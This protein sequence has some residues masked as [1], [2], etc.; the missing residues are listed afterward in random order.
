MGRGT[1]DG[2]RPVPDA[3]L[4]AEGL[5]RIDLPMRSVSPKVR[6]VNAWRLTRPDGSADLYDTGTADASAA[7]GLARGLRGIARLG[8]VV[9]GHAH[10]DH[11]GQA[12][13][14][15]A[16]HGADLLAPMDP[17]PPPADPEAARQDFLRFVGLPG[18]AGREAPPW[19][20]EGARPVAGGATLRLGRHLWRAEI[21]GGHAPASLLLL[22]ECGR[23][24][25]SADQLLPGIGSFVGVPV[26]RP[27]EDTLARQIAHMRRLAKLSPDVTALPGHGPAFTG[28]PAVADWQVA[29]Y[30]RR[31]ER[32]LGVLGNGPATCAALTESLFHPPTSDLGR[33]VQLRM[34]AALC[35][36][37]LAEGEA[38][39]AWTPEGA[40]L[41]ARAG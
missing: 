18:F 5:H 23:F 27:E 15:R 9:V 33:M 14:L 19:R 32:L 20:A 11:T 24:L 21:Q 12:H 3:A 30:Q 38:V 10:S 39:A 35:N 28:I 2:A 6:Q 8:A 40:R 26:H 25:I 36:R 16:A 37:L 29:S 34:A 17:S 1:G 41:F 13:A 22:S 7:A 4:A 31:L